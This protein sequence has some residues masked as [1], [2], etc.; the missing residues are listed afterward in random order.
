M[1]MEVSAS[2]C[3][4]GLRVGIVGGSIAGC[5]CAI[6][7]SRAGCEVEVF[8]RSTG[9]FEDRGAGITTSLPHLELL[10]QR[11]LVDSHFPVVEAGSSMWT[12][13][14]EGEPRGRIL[15]VQPASVAGMNWGQL[16]ANHRKRVPEKVYH[17]G[18]DV[19][20]VEARTDGPVTLVL[21]DGRRF[22][23]DLVVFADGYQSWGRGQL[24]PEV[25]AEYA[26][27]LMWR[28]MVEEERVPAATYGAEGRVEWAVHEGGLCILYAI[29]GVRE[30]C[31]SGQRRVNWAWYTL[32]PE[33]RLGELLTDKRGRRHE[34]SLPRGAAR[35]E[36][37][38]ALHEHARQ[39]LRGVAAEVICSTA[40][41]FIQVVYDLHVPA[42][43]R[44]RVCL[45]GDASSIARPHTAGGAIKAQQQAMALSQALRTHGTL[46]EALRA[47]NEEVWEAGDKQV[48]LGK[49]LGRAMLTE[50]PDWGAMD[51][52]RMVEWWDAT[53]RGMHVYYA[54]P[55]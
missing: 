3:A 12:V 33:A 19:T 8:E 16:F 34:T 28:G 36:H 51:E 40:E 17:R 26:G 9:Q 14:A 18:C 4:K 53:T 50:A 42:Y 21:E 1:D 25:K 55:R 41:P 37:V 29:P 49:A 10:K 39:A 47:W 2:E 46:D 22:T 31:A 38:R 6:E 32:T 15:R 13:P 7:L 23:F 20:G 24:F 35:G 45:M 48:S 11:D 44:G 52:A 43:V 27:Y 5:V 30:E 54:R